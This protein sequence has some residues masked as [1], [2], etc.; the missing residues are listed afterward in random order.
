[1]EKQVRGWPVLWSAI[2]ALSWGVASA[3]VAAPSSST[4]TVRVPVLSKVATGATFSL[5]A[6]IY[7]PTTG[8][9]HPLVLLSHG[10]S[11]GDLKQEAPQ[12]E[13][14]KFF[15]DRGY[16][17]LVS[18]RRGRGTSGGVSLESDVKNCNPASWRVGLNAAYEDVTAGLDFAATMSDVDATKVVLA[19]E[20]RGGFLS[21][22]YAAQGARRS[23]IIGVINFVGGWVAQAEDKC[24]VDFNEVAYR[25]YGGLTMI[26]ELWL[27]GDNDRFYSTRSI[28][29]Y[30]KAYTSRGGRL[31][32]DLI[33]GVPNNGH[34]LPGYPDL[35]SK[36]VDRYL[37]SR[38][39]PAAAHR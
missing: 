32:F 12:T 24:P 21:V 23:R 33:A 18:M 15:T 10:S 5:E 4:R 16:V 27:Y 8:G 34:W 31:T 39:L 28:R 29:S 25:E 17:V 3:Q 35:W 1:M 38:G 22:A 19:G 11:G 26:P 37:A 36:Q 13:Q 20:S 2:T 6:F 30:P 9:R 7:R 14:A